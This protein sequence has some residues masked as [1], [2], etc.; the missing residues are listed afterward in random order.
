MMD[1][2]EMRIQNLNIPENFAWFSDAIHNRPTND[3]II[4]VRDAITAARREGLEKGKRV[5]EDMRILWTATGREQGKQ[6]GAREEC[7][8]IA[9]YC[10]ERFDCLD[11]G[12]IVAKSDELYHNADH[13]LHSV[14]VIE[15]KHLGGDGK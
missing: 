8:R 6:E 2:Q 9:S 11:C 7:K 14:F 1:E 10:V 13:T 5:T 12:K 3:I 15:K 4:M